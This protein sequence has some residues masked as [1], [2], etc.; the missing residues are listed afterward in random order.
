ML[1]GNEHK[2]L[3]GYSLCQE[4]VPLCLCVPPTYKHTRSIYAAVSPSSVRM[5]PSICHSAPTY[6]HS[7]AGAAAASNTSQCANLMPKEERRRGEATTSSIYAVL[8][9]DRSALSAARVR[10]YPR[11]AIVGNERD[12]ALNRWWRFRTFSQC[13][14]AWWSYSLFPWL[15]IVM[16]CSSLCS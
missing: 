16:L 7:R 10:V 13:Y 1:V 12:H 3:G 14:Y 15:G 9:V 6:M 11:L 5:A 8:R 4:G 2:S